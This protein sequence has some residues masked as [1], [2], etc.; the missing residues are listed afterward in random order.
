MSLRR[1]LRR[2]VCS[3]CPCAMCCEASPGPALPPEAAHATFTLPRGARDVRACVRG[4]VETPSFVY[5]GRL[6]V[7][8]IYFRGFVQP[9]NK[10]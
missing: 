6:F 2:W 4:W 5:H 3:L 7:P 8:M 9:L 10:L 1:R